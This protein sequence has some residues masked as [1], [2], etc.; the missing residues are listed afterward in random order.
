MRV[1]LFQE[2]QEILKKLKQLIQ[3]EGLTFDKV[4]EKMGFS[5]QELYQK[6]YLKYIE[7]ELLNKVIEAIKAC[8]ADKTRVE[9]VAEFDG[10]DPLDCLRYFCKTARRFINGEIG[11]MDHQMK[12]AQVIANF[13]KTQDTTQLYRQMEVIEKGNNIISGGAV[14]RRGGIMSRRRRR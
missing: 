3:S 8:V 7:L 14:R 12:I 10:D 9:D 13:E 5:K 6:L 4:A 1:V 2:K 11:N